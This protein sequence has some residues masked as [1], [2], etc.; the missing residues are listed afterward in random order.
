MLPN[1]LHRTAA[2]VAMLMGSTLIVACAQGN[3]GGVIITG[4]GS[5]PVDYSSARGQAGRNGPYGDMC[6]SVKESYGPQPAMTQISANTVL[7]LAT[8]CIYDWDVVPG[9]GI[10]VDQTAQQATSGLDAL[11][12]A[13]RLPSEPPNDWP[14]PSPVVPVI[15]VTDSTGRVFHPAIPT[16]GCDQVLDAVAQAIMDLP[17]VDVSTSRA[18]QQDT[19]SDTLAMCTNTWESSP[20]QAGGNTGAEAI[21]PDLTPPGLLVCQYDLDASSLTNSYQNGKLTGAYTL[22]TSASRPFMAA[23]ANAPLAAQCDAPQVGF[24]VVWPLYGQGSFIIVEQGGCYRALVDGDTV[25]RQLDA[26]TVTG[27]GG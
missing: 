17:W 10:W 6:D 9:D 7:V 21:A 5:T 8:R 24:D 18:W 26:T 27:L 23:V 2:L 19:E 13:L 3:G 16:N 14:C 12:A 4:D 20:A 22:D 25:L 1:R 15:T 11:A